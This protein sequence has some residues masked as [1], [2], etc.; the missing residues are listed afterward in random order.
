VNI[1]VIGGGIA[2]LTATYE[3]SKVGHQVHLFEKQAQL[4]GQAA[5]FEVAGTR[6]ERFY[7]HIFGSDVDIIQLIGELGLNDRLEWLNSKVGF[8]YGGKI[9]DFVTPIELLKFSPLSLVDRV[10]LGLITMYLRRYNKWQALEGVTARKW[11]LK[12][13]GRRS[14]DVVWGPMLRNKFGE[15]ADE[16][17]MVWLWGK[18]HLRLSSRK[19]GKEQLGYM[20]GSYGVMVDKLAERIEGSDGKI[21]VS[22]PVE[23]IVVEAGKATGI[24]A[25][26]EIYPFDMIIATAPSP[27][28][29]KMVP[30]LPSDYAKKLEDIRYQG[31]VVLAMTLKRPLSHIYWMNISDPEIPFIALVEHTN[32][33]PPSV[34]GGKRILYV[35]NYLPMD[36]PLYSMGKDELIARYLP[37]IKKF[38]PE[39]DT[40]WIEGSYLFRDDAGQPIVGTNYSS[41]IPDHKT[42]ISGLYLANTTQI[43]PEDRGMNYSVRLGY[44]VA[45]T[46]SPAG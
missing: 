16:V 21:S 32:F 9:Y 40:D 38:N 44:K 29:L 22:T 46:V 39:F 35:S 6:L 4:G 18:I 14:Y 3:L 19:E 11:L 2:G 43:Y 31:A 13:G 1:G 5:T 10:R 20:K 26:G 12:Y 36:S 33:V 34:Y 45:Q 42:P 23:K 17:G 15:S 41:K 7:H 25:G 30:E 28:F 24:K 8:F 27:I 37:H